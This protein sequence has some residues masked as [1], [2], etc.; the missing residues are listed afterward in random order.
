MPALEVVDL[1]YRIMIRVQGR[2]V[3][4]L[5]CFEFGHVRATCQAPWCGNCKTV[6]HALIACPDPLLSKPGTGRVGASAQPEGPG[7]EGCVSFVDSDAG[8][9]GTGVAVTAGVGAGPP[10]PP[11]CRC[12]KQRRREMD[13]PR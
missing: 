5:R 10:P 13:L 7:G 2:Q 1:L 8:N 4:C 9:D 3:Q 6:G 11:Q 12:R